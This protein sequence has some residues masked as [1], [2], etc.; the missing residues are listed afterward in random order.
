MK[1]ICLLIL[2]LIFPFKIF[3][4]NISDFEIKKEY[5]IKKL[6]IRVYN[7]LSNFTNFKFT[8]LI[9]LINK[10][11]QKYEKNKLIKDNLKLKNLAILYALKYIIKEVKKEK[12][13]IENSLLKIKVIDDKRCINCNTNKIIESLKDIPYLKWVE[14]SVF[15]FKSKQVEEYLKYNNITKLPAIILSTNNI[16]DDNTM[17]PYLKKIRSWEYFLNIGSI[18]NPFLK[19]SDRWY[20]IVDIDILKNIKKNSY[21]NWNKYAD[22]TWLEYSDIECPFCSKLHTDWTEKKIIE[23]YKW[24]VNII[25]QH[26]PLEFHKNAKSWAE[27]L[28][29]SWEQ[30]WGNIFYS[31][32]EEYYIEKTLTFDLILKK[33]IELWVNKDNLNKCY[34]N[35]KYLN[36]IN[37]Q[38]KIWNTIFWITWTPWNV[39]INNKTR[40]YIIIP[41][42]YPKDYFKSVIDKLLK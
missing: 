8:K 28:E 36:K 18:F 9:K 23:K 25:F 3:A 20:L 33:A 29:C 12:Q 10:K 6:E 7:K 30:L 37:N 16:K 41:W 2:L 31:L 11:I 13:I 15:D 21:I 27:I 4:Y 38:M 34:E 1:K 39:I 24:K 42:A 32:L 5:Y 35:S 26:F 22:I 19:R 14:F 40:E 17:K